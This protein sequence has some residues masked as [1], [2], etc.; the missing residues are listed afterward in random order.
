MGRPNDRERVPHTR[1]ADLRDAGNGIWIPEN[2][3]VILETEFGI[4]IWGTVIIR[5]GWMLA[6]EYSIYTE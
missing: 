4:R 5:G 2:R 6:L 3:N 1:G